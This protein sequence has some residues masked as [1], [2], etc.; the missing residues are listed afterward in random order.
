VELKELHDKRRALLARAAE[1]AGAAASEGRGMTDEEVTNHKLAWDEQGKLK[2]TIERLQDA[3]REQAA[4]PTQTAARNTVAGGRDHVGT[5]SRE[6]P[7][8]YLEYRG[9]Q[10]PKKSRAVRQAINRWFGAEDRDQAAAEIRA[11][12][13]DID[14]SGGF[15]RPD[16][17]FVASLIQNVDNAVFIRG[18]ATVLTIGSAGSL[19]YPSLNTD[20]SDPTW[21]SELSIGAADTALDIGR[22]E[23]RTNPLAKSILVSNTLLRI[24]A[25]AGAVNA[26]SLVRERFGY[27]FGTT[28]ENAYMIG[29]GASQ[30]LGLFIASANG[31]TTTRDISAGNTTTAIGADNLIRNKYNLLPQYRG[32]PST[33]WIMNRTVV[34]DI[35][36]LVDGN[37]QYMWRA[38]LVGGAPDTILGTT[39]IESEY[40]PNTMTT[41]LYVGLIGD[42]SQYWIVDSLGFQIQVLRELYAG[43]NQTGF[44]GR[45]EGDGAPV[46]AQ[47]FSRMQLA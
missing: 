25:L 36:L 2:D 15:L 27:V 37:G 42:L 30:P 43:T 9:M 38:G 4:M 22:R 20:A 32:R 19:G 46:L 24:S 5:E 31:I 11:L 39:V 14:V 17:E 1:I 21:T 28:L 6:A 40:A 23:F 35:S 29:T 18:L 26:E 34:R 33:R 44:V 8:G 3:Q 12:Q 13:V 47:A 45:Y 10:I 16:Q 7:H 41:G